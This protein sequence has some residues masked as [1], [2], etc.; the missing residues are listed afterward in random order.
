MAA[1]LRMLDER[2]I[3]IDDVGLRRPTLDEV[4]LSLT[5]QPVAP[6]DQSF[7]PAADAA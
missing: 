5:G 4:F 6:A 1:V 7:D 3:P 2:T